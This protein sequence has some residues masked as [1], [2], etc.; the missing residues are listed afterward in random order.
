MSGANTPGTV[1]FVGLGAMGLPMALNLVRA[2]YTVQGFDLNPAA[3]AALHEASGIGV[4]SAAAAA[5]GA[6]TLIL[7]VVN[8]AQAEAV[9]FEAGAAEALPEGGSVIIMATCPPQSV[10]AMATR[11]EAMGRRL[12]DAPVSGGVAGATAA[13][14]TIMVAAP[15]ASFAAVRP[16]LD[17]M[18]GKVV[19][20]GRARTLGR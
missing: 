7:M 18:G 19:H 4:A 16:V 13:S 3:L 2:G 20:V 6:D 8:A 5:N 15:A 10:A 11:V 14:L 17:A 1:G 9:L 12:I